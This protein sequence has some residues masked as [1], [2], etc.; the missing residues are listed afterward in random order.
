MEYSEEDEVRDEMC[1]RIIY[2]DFSGQERLHPVIK[3]WRGEN[4]LMGRVLEADRRCDSGGG[5]DAGGQ[6]G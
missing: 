1:I 5:R 2:C 3:G 6:L 4:G